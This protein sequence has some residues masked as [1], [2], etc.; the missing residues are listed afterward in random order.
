MLNLLQ[1]ELKKILRRK[2][3]YIIWTLMIL[4]CFLNNY[5]YF[6]DYDSNG[7][8]KY[9]EQENLNLTKKQLQENLKKYDYN[10]TSK[11]TTYIDIK[12][13]IDIIE[14]REKFAPNSWQQYIIKNSLYDMI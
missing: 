5:L 6:K 10:N 1:V 13:K 9:L 11:D 14:L 12:T 2:S 7:N 8:Y 3:I 4:F